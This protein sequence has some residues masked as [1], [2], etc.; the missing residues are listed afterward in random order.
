MNVICPKCG[1]ENT[2]PFSD[3]K[4][5]QHGFECQDCHKDFGVDDGKTLKEWEDSLVDFFYERVYKDKSKKRISIQVKEDKVLLCPSI[6]YP[7]KMMQPIEAQDITMMWPALK[8][9]FFEKIF[10]LDWNRINVG[11]VTG[12]DESFDIKM[13][14]T[15]KP[16]M[17]FSGT[18]RFPP[19]LKVL[20][21]LFE[22]FFELEK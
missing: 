12:A 8:E 4:L 5:N 9:L 21:Q 22:S 17:T 11:L 6:V 20:D 2:V 14:F 16:D 1:K 18:N 7:N 19:Y 3:I 13:K 10:I 15:S